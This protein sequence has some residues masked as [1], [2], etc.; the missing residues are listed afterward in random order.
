MTQQ[1]FVS[2]DLAILIP[3]LIILSVLTT[4]LTVQANILKEHENTYK[5]LLLKSKLQETYAQT[6]SNL[7]SHRLDIPLIVHSP[8]IIHLFSG[9]THPISHH[10]GNLKPDTDSQALTTIR[11]NYQNDLQ[12]L[13]CATFGDSIALEACFRHQ[14]PDNDIDLTHLLALNTN[15]ISEW[16][17]IPDGNGAC[18][19]FLM[20]NLDGM[21][22]TNLSPHAWCSI[23]VMVPIESLH[24]L[25]LDQSENLRLLSHLGTETL[26]NQPLLKGL[27]SITLV[28]SPITPYSITFLELK[29]LTSQSHHINLSFF[30]HL[31]RAPLYNYLL[32]S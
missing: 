29:A 18:R 30:N 20:T 16:T 7:D 27:I 15:G 5:Q 14:V 12:V 2:G 17:A 31:N 6:V 13:N 21:I 22:A 10:P 25:Y 3:C 28:A 9:E 19:Q 24:T 26:E 4:V 32:N 8:G 1:G 11:L 23:H